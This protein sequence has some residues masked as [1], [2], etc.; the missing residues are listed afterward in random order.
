MRLI[1]W[2]KVDD[3]PRYSISNDGQVRNDITAKILKQQI[4]RS[5]YSVRLYNDNGPKWKRV[6]R[7]VASA[8]CGPHSDEMEVNH[9][10]GD[11][12]NNNADNLEWVTKRENQIHAIFV[13]GKEHCFENLKKM[14][15]KN[16]IP[17]LCVETGEVFASTRKA[18]EA[19]GIYNTSIT[20]AL[21]GTYKT[22]GGYRWEVAANG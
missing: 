4:S 3:F 21:H 6:H 13:L 18:G 7:L 16:E 14:A 5:Y 11:K 15:V 22:A 17:V 2:R 20:K 10:D 9:I 1:E 12:L 8:F 19:K